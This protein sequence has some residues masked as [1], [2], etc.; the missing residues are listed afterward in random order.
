MTTAA[1][2]P[3]AARDVDLLVSTADLRAALSSVLAHAGGDPELPELHRVVCDVQADHLMWWATDTLSAGLAVC[4]VHSHQAPGLGRF[5]ILPSDAKKLL[6]IFKAGKESL[7]DPQYITQFEVLTE[8]DGTQHVQVTDQSG[9]MPGRRYRVPQVYTAD[10]PGP[11]IDRLCA[12]LQ[13]RASSW[14]DEH[15]FNGEVLARFKAA[16]GAY[17]EPIQVGAVTGSRTLL[18]RCGP[19]FLGALM[20][21]HAS[22]QV[23]AERAAW[24]DAWRDR[25][26]EPT[27]ASK[28]IW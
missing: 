2:A 12:S 14:A 9:L 16:T 18:V 1:D 21:V 10:Q 27:P 4:E 15:A 7:E 3:P 23:E 28:E 20:S 13:T 25:L 22:E 5:A 24:R 11:P 6:A 19:S 17:H 8:P 26:P